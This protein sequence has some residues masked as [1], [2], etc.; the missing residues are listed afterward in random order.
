[1]VGQKPNGPVVQR[2]VRPREFF[3][4]WGPL[5]G[6]FLWANARDKTIEVDGHR[7]RV[8]VHE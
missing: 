3:D 5:W 1:M 2:T 6:R 7:V 8:V 4:G